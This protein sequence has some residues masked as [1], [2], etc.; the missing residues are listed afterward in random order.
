MT[1]FN[2][3]ETAVN[4]PKRS[5]CLILVLGDTTSMSVVRTQCPNCGFAVQD[6]D[7][8]PLCGANLRDTDD[9]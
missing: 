6:G 3:S 1:L 4:D 5:E 9:V 7:E 8:C 2:P